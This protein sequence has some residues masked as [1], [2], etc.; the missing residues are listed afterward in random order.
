MI[1]A[2]IGDICG[3]VYEF[4]NEK[5]IN[6]IELFKEGSYPTDDSVMSVAVARALIDARGRSDERTKMLI[7]DS[8]HYFGHI[9]P[10]AGY[11]QTFYRWLKGNYRNAYNS[12]GNGSAMRVSSVG[13]LYDS[14]EETL[15][16]AKLSAEVTHD[17]P[18]GIK[19]AEAIA[20]CIYLAR[21]GKDKK[22]IREYVEKNFYKMNFR[23]DTIRPDYEF[24]VSCQGSCP[25]AIK[26]FL[27]STSF[28]DSIKLAISIGGD[29]DTI[30]AM[31]GSIA[32]AYYGIPD[33]ILEKL[34][35]ALSDYTSRRGHVYRH[36]ILLDECIRFR[37]YYQS[38]HHMDIAFLRNMP[39]GEY[40][41]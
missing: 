24:D 19:G 33:E 27:E 26:A 11:G 6:K 23:L 9:F 7:I 32:E 18:E 17:H 4:N 31:T 35:F 21:T 1:G 30:A 12:W 16:Y 20:A 38:G 5:D 15:K 28:E 40:K 22:E 39:D 10:D 2:I 36:S 3:S 14:L 25:Q 29:S 34:T 41:N 8:M 37:H 13:W